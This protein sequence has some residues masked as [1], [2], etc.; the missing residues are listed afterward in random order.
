MEGGGGIGRWGWLWKGGGSGGGWR[1]IG[2]QGRAE[3]QCVRLRAVLLADG[4]VGAPR[5]EGNGRRED[6]KWGDMW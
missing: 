2:R 3:E 1:E 4:C 5:W 6:S